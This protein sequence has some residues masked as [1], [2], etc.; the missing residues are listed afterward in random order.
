MTAKLNNGNFK[1]PFWGKNHALVRGRDQLGMQST[2]IATYGGLVPGITNL[3]KRIRYYGF[4]CWL[5]EFYAEHIG[6]DNVKVF[7]KF[8]RRSEL[9]FAY[10]MFFYEKEATG[11][12]GNDYA[13][14]H[15]PPD[16]ADSLI[17]IGSGADKDNGT[18]TY[19]QY[20]LGAF[21]QYYLGSLLTLELVQ[22]RE[23]SPGIYICTTYGRELA[24]A[25]RENVS[26]SGKDQAKIDELFKRNF[27]EGI[28]MVGEMEA[29]ATAFA[30]TNIPA[31]SAEWQVYNRLLLGKDSIYA[32]PG[33]H[34]TFRKETIHYYLKLMNESADPKSHFYHDF[35]TL[36]YR[37][38]SEENDVLPATL[39]GWF[40]Y[41]LNEYSNYIHSTVF[42]GVLLYL[43]KKEYPVLLSNCLEEMVSG[44]GQELTRNYS[45]IVDRMERTVSAILERLD[46]ATQTVFDLCE[47]MEDAVSA[48]NHLAAMAHSL[49][50]FLTLYRSHAPMRPQIRRYSQA[51]NMARDGDVV[52]NFKLIEDYRDK[53]LETFV[54]KLILHNVIQ[55]HIYV[56]MRKMRT[57]QQ[58]TLKFIYD[59]NYLYH[60]E[61]VKPMWST[62]RLPS[63]HQIL[64]DLKLIDEN[65][66]LTEYGINFLKA[67]KP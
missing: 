16:G 49:I 31:N 43:E 20:N 26:D 24:D 35:P 59:N 27:E 3:T 44:L 66:Q 37:W 45:S 29:L 9:L 18:D 6:I 28:L 12:P 54:E 25:Y 1:V 61:T 39:F 34:Q 8:M 2:S 33:Q 42:W 67:S 51:H 57:H 46:T 56:A 17:D 48:G 19:W 62:P 32:Q 36:V 47:R 15:V 14:K 22:G 23:H 52:E 5:L 10:M 50:F 60:L 11:I 40:Y 65:K 21:G 63:L 13:T 53:M 7:R 41:E 55:R 38:Q 64:E 58:N 4:Y 30:I